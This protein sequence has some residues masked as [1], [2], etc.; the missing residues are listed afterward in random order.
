MHMRHSLASS[1][2]IVYADVITS[3]AVLRISISLTQIEQGKYRVAFDLGQVKKRFH[4][5]L[6]DDERVPAGYRISVTNNHATHVLVKDSI[7]FQI[8]ENAVHHDPFQM[9][10]QQAG[11]RSCDKLGVAS[12]ALFRTYSLLSNLL[13]I[14]PHRNNFT[15][16]SFHPTHPLKLDPAKRLFAIP[17]VRYQPATGFRNAV[18]KTG[19]VRG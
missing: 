10:A 19:N 2:T 13:F 12:S 7:W 4:V 15:H 8:T 6:W 9:P 14:D 18:I 11:N 5:A 1:S 3:W 17:T 16:S